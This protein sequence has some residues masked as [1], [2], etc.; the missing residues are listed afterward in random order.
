VKTRAFMFR[1]NGASLG[2]TCWR[3]ASRDFSL[4]GVHGTCLKGDF[5][6]YECNGVTRS[7]SFAESGMISLNLFV[8]PSGWY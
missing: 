1:N 4:G 8:E 2:I 7:F 3:T 6:F 5:I